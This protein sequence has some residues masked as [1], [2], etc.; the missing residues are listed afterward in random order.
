MS[1]MVLKKIFKEQSKNLY[2]LH[3]K[4]KMLFILEDSHF[5]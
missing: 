4:N 2:D 3:V 5:K 1:Y